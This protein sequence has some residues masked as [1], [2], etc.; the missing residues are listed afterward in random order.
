MF[1]R[2]MLAM[3]N[4]PEGPKEDKKEEEERKNNDE[5]DDGALFV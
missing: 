5:D 1:Y 4:F 2:L 3:F